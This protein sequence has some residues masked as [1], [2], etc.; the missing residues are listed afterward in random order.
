MRKEE[1]EEGEERGGKKGEWKGGWKKREGE[2]R[3]R[4]R[5]WLLRV[6]AQPMEMM[7]KKEA[8]GHSVIYTEVTKVLFLS[9]R[10][11]VLSEVQHMATGA[12]M[13]KIKL[14]T[15]FGSWAWHTPPL[16]R[17]S[18][19]LTQATRPQIKSNQLASW[20]LRDMPGTWL[21]ALHKLT[22]LLFINTPWVNTRKL[23]LVAFKKLALRSKK[24]ARVGVQI[25][26]PPGPLSAYPRP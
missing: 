4:E 11:H 19:K 23:R 26:M 3:K 24:V 12:S 21:S 18:R 16:S 1:K 14:Q 7:R 8:R 10:V 22:H 20:I 17:L 15:Q 2:G 13:N 9:N 6:L 25:Q 5:E